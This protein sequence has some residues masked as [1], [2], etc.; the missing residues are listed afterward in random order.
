[1][2]RQVID[3][4]VEMIC[5]RMHLDYA[6]YRSFRSNPEL[7]L[8]DIYADRETKSHIAK[9]VNESVGN[10]DEWWE[11][12]VRCCCSNVAY[13]IPPDEMPPL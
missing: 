12:R 8:A 10:V 13:D 11:D 2:E 6:Y 5:N 9:L 7:A 4:V 3:K 1:M